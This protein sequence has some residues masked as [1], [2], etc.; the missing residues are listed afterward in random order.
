MGNS[1]THLLWLFI[2]L[3][4]TWASSTL[5]ILF[6]ENLKISLPL[7]SLFLGKLEIYSKEKKSERKQR[8]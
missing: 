2:T 1:L 3:L 7:K 4:F 6:S 8:I 5:I